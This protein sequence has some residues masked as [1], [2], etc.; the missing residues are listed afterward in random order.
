MWA[1]LAGTYLILCKKPGTVVPHACRTVAASQESS[2]RARARLSQTEPET[3]TAKETEKLEPE[4]DT[5]RN[6]ERQSTRAITR[7][8]PVL[9]ETDMVVMVSE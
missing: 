1:F 9:V 3:D 7:A 2:R 8:E 6:R 4:N 5:P